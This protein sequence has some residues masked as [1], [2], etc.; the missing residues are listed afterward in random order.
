MTRRVQKF[1]KKIDLP[2]TAQITHELRMLMAFDAV[3]ASLAAAPDAVR[4]QEISEL[5][6]LLARPDMHFD[7][8][9]R[10]VMDLL[11]RH[12]RG[13]QPTPPV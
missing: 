13:P 5:E 3:D 8:N 7:V 10:D 11:R 12:G 6:S 1:G 4:D 2:S 9:S